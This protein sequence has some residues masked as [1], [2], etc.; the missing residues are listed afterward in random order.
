VRSTS[1]FTNWPGL[2]LS[3]AAG[4]PAIDS[5]EVDGAPTHDLLETARDAKP[6][7]AALAFVD[8]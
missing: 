3:L 5:G 2:D 4:S 8:D 7:I 1:Y 6:D